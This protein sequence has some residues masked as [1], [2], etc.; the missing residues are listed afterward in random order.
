MNNA[1]YSEDDP[2]SWFVRKFVNTTNFAGRDV[3][4]RVRVRIDRIPEKEQAK[5]L[6]RI[7]STAISWPFKLYINRNFYISSSLVKYQL[8]YNKRQNNSYFL[9]WYT[10]NW[11]C[12][13]I[14]GGYFRLLGLATFCDFEA[15]LRA[16]QNIRKRTA[17]ADEQHSSLS[18]IIKAVEL[19]IRKWR[20]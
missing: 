5:F 4:F 7:S 20:L 3:W 12:P 14:I 6:L 2:P 11:T 10:V 18:S 19:S 17:E 8:Q 9:L 15:Y 13:S 16:L 1:P